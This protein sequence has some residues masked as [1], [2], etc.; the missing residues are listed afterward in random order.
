MSAHRH[1]QH[2]PRGALLGAGAVILFSVGLAAAARHAHVT[3]PHVASPPPR[4]VIQVRF[5]DHKDG[6]IA[7][8]DGATGR[9][10]TIVPPRSNGFVRGVLRGM[11]RTR[12]LEAM[13]PRATFRLAREADGHLT[14][15]DPDTHRRIELDSFGPSNTA[16][17]SELLDA[18]LRATAGTVAA[19]PTQ[20]TP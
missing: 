2:V 9:E 17:F 12:K 20:A 6:A 15:E 1:E 11:F 19:A 13:S 16:A 10:L 7:M 5:E 8:L 3:A 4:D 18:G 14:L